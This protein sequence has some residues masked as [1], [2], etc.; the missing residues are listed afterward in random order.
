MPAPRPGTPAERGPRRRPPARRGA[1]HY[2]PSARLSPVYPRQGEIRTGIE[3]RSGPGPSGS[4]PPASAGRGVPAA[5]RPKEGKR[6]GARLDE[7]ASDPDDSPPDDRSAPLPR[8]AARLALNIYD[9]PVL[10]DLWTVEAVR[11][12]AHELLGL[13]ERDSLDH[14]A[15]DAGRLG[16]V[17]RFVADVTR[18]RYPDLQIPLHSR[19]RHLEAPDGTSRWTRAADAAGLTGL[20][21][22]RSAVELVVVSAL[23]DAGAGR[24]WRYR[25]PST[26]TALDRSEGLAA[27]TFD[28]YCGGALSDDPAHP[29]RADATALR[30][31]DPA[32]FARAFQLDDRNPLPGVAGRI[33]CL[34][35]LGHAVATRPEFAGRSERTGGSPAPRRLGHLFD[36]LLANAPG[37]RIPARDLFRTGLIALRG[38]IGRALGDV[39]R[40]PGIRRP[41]PTDR[42]L[43]LHKL[44]QWFTWSLIE[45]LAEGAVTVTGAEALTGLAEYRNGGLLLDTEVLVPRRALPDRAL[46]TADPIVVEWRGL[47]VALLDRLRPQV[48]RELGLAESGFS[49]GQLLEGGAW[50]AGRRIAADLREDGGPPVRI[51]SDGTVF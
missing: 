2:L 47:T 39:W 9:E 44:F 11:E 33:R 12:R 50:W 29:F 34:R 27:A 23:L 21:R 4:T 32:A 17:A 19:W 1:P 38:V 41:G 35:T 5:P 24:Q 14:F 8:G 25:D 43:P 3:A 28:L 42:L 15:V 37:G 20:E 7:A 46:S 40:H 31:T 22:G 18:A 6:G 26:G 16:A 51:K 36:H 30:R 13:A 10:R 48:A 45:P 49:L